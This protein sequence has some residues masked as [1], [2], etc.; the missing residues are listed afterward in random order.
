MEEPQGAC[1]A[2]E[3]MEVEGGSQEGS[4]TAV[5]NGGSGGSMEVEHASGQ[6]GLTGESDTD[7]AEENDPGISSGAEDT[8]LA[9]QGDG[10]AGSQ[11]GSSH[12]QETGQDVSQVTVSE[13]GQMRSA[14][15]ASQTKNG[16]LPTPVGASGAGGTG[17]TSRMGQPSQ[18]GDWSDSSSEDEGWGR[19]WRG[20]VSRNCLLCL[21]LA[22]HSM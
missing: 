18:T 13:T 1:E 7:P 22:C 17:L 12:D 6:T 16:S 11:P 3:D 2:V 8:G 10:S 14:G 20:W 21:S 9:S 15:Q 4:Q 19:P 5:N